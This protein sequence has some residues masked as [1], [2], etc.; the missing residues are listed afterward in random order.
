M[1]E[2]IHHCETL[3]ESVRIEKDGGYFGKEENWVLVVTRLATDEDLEENHYLEEVGETIW[4]TV[5]EISHCPYCGKFL[6][7]IRGRDPKT[8]HFDFSS[9]EARRC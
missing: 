3:P 6:G 4:C 7:E 1:E 5:A 9:W 2:R 8:A